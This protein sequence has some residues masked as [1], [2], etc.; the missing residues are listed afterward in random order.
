[1]TMLRANQVGYVKKYLNDFAE[2]RLADGKL[3]V[4]KYYDALR[5][6]DDRPDLRSISKT[7]F[8]SVGKAVKFAGVGTLR[9][10][11]LKEWDLSSFPF[12]QALPDRPTGTTKSKSGRVCFV[13]H[14]F[15]ENIE[16]S[17]RYNLQHL[18]E[19]YRITLQW[20][21]YDLQA[22]SLLPAIIRM[23]D[24]ADFC[25]FDNL[26]TLN[27]PNVYIE[28]GIAYAKKRPMIFCEYAGDGGRKP[29]ADSGSMPT[30]LT[31]ILTLRYRSYEEF[32]RTLYFR[33]PS[34]LERHRLL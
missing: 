17:L 28:A 5:N 24:E 7:L 13:G 18:F 15:T 8:T 16:R 9:L 4:D 2:A 11:L 3:S 21:G 31:E 25:L 27:K 6:I 1:M 12:L 10:V 34:F 20:S 14:R 32:C 33:L 19:P 30:D 26:G 23:I 22:E 29:P